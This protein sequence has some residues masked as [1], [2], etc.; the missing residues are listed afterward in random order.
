NA[1]LSTPTLNTRGELKGLDTVVLLAALESEPVLSGRADASWNLASRGNS[2][3]A[4]IAALEGEIRLD[5]EEL[6]LEQLGVER[7]LCQV[8]AQVNQEPLQA[9]LPARSSFD[10]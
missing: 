10:S 1:R 7:M 5:T 8:I 4:L 9:E 3:N 2:R 6:A